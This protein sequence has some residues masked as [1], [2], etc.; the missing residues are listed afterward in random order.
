M[1]QTVG[2]TYRGIGEYQRAI[3]FLARAA[4]LRKTHLGADHAD[5][6]ATLHMLALAHGQAGKLPEAIK[7]F[8]QVRDAL[9]RT[10]GADNPD[11]LTVLDNLAMAY[12]F[13]GKLPEATEL[14]ERVRNVAVKKLGPDHPN[15]L[16]ALDDLAMAYLIAG[17]PLQAIELWERVRDARVKQGADHPRILITLG[18]LAGAYQAAGKMPQAI[19]LFERVRDAEVNRLGADNPATFVTLGNLAGAYKDAGKLSQAIEIFEQLRDAEVRKLGP[20][21]P[22]TLTTL[23]NLAGAYKDA[24]KLSTAIELFEQAHDGLV[25]NVGADHPHTLA[26]LNN[27]A[28][29][30]QAAGKLPKALPLFEQAAG[31][32]EKR[33]FL[34]RNAG[35]MIA[36]AISAYEAAMQFDKANAWRRKWA[37]AVK[38]KAGAESRDYA[39]ELASLGLN[40]LRQKKYHDAE[41]VLRECLA[42][43]EKLLEK[44]QATPWLV[45]DTK[46]MLGEALLGQKRLADAEPLL[47]VGYEGLKADEKAIPEVARQQRMSEAIQRLIDL[48]LAMN[49]PNNV[50]RWQ[51]ELA[52][53]H[54]ALRLGGRFL[55]LGRRASWS[56]DGKRIAFAPRG[57]DEAILVYDLATEKTSEFS[58]DGRDPAWAGKEGRWIAYV[59]KSIPADAIWVAGVPAGIPFR[60]ATGSMPTWLADG[61]TL[62]FEAFDKRQLMST[63][64]AGTGQFSQPSGRAMVPYQ[65]PSVSPDGKKVAYRHGGDLVIQQI[66]GGEILRRYALPRGNGFLGGWSPDAKELGFGGFGDGD[67]MPCIILETETGLARQVGPGGLTLPSWSP[68][69][70]KIVFDLRFGKR[71]LWLIETAAI[72]KLPTFKMETRKEKSRVAD[73]TSRASQRSTSQANPEKPAGPLPQVRRSEGVPA[74]KSNDTETANAKQPVKP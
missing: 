5:T 31:G 52:S 68:D 24:G 1:L 10:L 35:S 33:D 54:P 27:L 17:R 4:E 57:R 11:T 69:G 43:R 3:E 41:P 47:V 7:L 16:T 13:A 59:R 72:K 50:K 18:N 28:L 42:I 70:S 21:H 6:L 61:K 58:S 46:S 12:L 74:Q 71:E 34:D 51:A 63:E 73:T 2:N 8:E 15:T 19:E 62:F 36:C 64:I 9:V 23:N 22:Y 49:K 32:A 39:Q 30:Y 66:D 14:F 55:G 53:G 26:A 40:L 29:A 48:A 37:A 45:A 67:P 60:V 38:Q 56:P 44:R 25:K 20:G 65:Y